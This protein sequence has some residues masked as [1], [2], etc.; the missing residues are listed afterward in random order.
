MKGI[1]MFL[2][3]PIVSAVFLLAATAAAAQPAY[4]VSVPS[5]L[6]IDAGTGQVLLEKEP[7]RPVPPA[8]LAK[9]MTLLVALDEVK[10]GR[11]S[12]DDPV[13]ASARASRMTG[14]RVYLREGEVHTLLELLKAVAIAGANDAAVAV[15]EHI[16]GTE[17]AFVAMM[18]ARAQ[19]LGMADSRFANAHGLPPAEGEGEAYTTAHDIAVAARAL[20]ASHPEVLEWTRIRVERFRDE[21][22]FN[23]YNTNNLVGRYEGLDGLRTGYLEE[24]GYLIVATAQRSGV[25]LL[26][27]IMGARDEKER[28]SQTIS[29]L[30]YGFQRFIPVTIPT[31]RVGE[32]RIPAGVPEWIP[33]EVRGP[34]RVLVPRGGPAE[35]EVEIEALPPVLPIAA[36]DVVGEYVIRHG[37]RELLRLPLYA[38][39][40]VKPA[41]WLV[42]LWRRIRDAL[43]GGR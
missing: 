14:S 29:L 8:S 10:A 22:L 1:A 41:S 3:T 13:R 18:N 39:E 28:E 31:G 26:A 33:V 9:V 19:E 34:G 4:D 15:A 12:L 32:A 16:A 43:G 21:P 38:G 23:L 40:E 2:L 25:R 37:E 6:L 42:R 27:V 20:I 35:V 11:V 36:G 7:R 17:S 24:S 30:D 5:A